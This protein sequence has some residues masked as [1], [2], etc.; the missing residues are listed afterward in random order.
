[1]NNDNY[2]SVIDAHPAKL[3]STQ[4]QQETTTA[5]NLTHSV[6]SANAI[7]DSI[8]GIYLEYCEILI[9]DEKEVQQNLFS[10]KLGRLSQ[11]Y[12]KYKIKGTNT[13]FFTLWSKLPKNKKPTYAYIYCDFKLHKFETYCT[14]ITVE[15]IDYNIQA[16]Y[17]YPRQVSQPQKYT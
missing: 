16:I 17:L 8:S 5:S 1:M 6:N 11:S 4:S 14:R 15:E 12:N 13:L 2:L 9:T 3:L 7:Y 10:N